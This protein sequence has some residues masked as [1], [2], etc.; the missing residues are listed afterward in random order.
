M[1][2]RNL[3]GE[4]LGQLYEHWYR[5]EGVQPFGCVAVVDGETFTSAEL[6]EAVNRLVEE[7]SIEERQAF[8]GELLVNGVHRAEMEGYAQADLA[9]ISKDQRDL[10]MIELAKAY[11]EDPN[12]AGR[13]YSQFRDHG[14]EDHR[15]M[16]HFLLLSVAGFVKTTA[17]G[18]YE[19]T[20]AG[21]DMIRDCRRV[22]AL[23]DRFVEIE[24]LAP[25]PRG[26][27][28]ETLIADFI[29][30]DGS[31]WHALWNVTTS[32]EQ[33]D[34]TIYRDREYYLM[35][36]KWEKGPAGAPYV[37]ELYGK[38]ENRAGYCGILA[39]MGGFT[40]GA[41]TQVEEYKNRRVILLFGNDSIRAIIATSKTFE[42][43]LTEK[44]HALVTKGV[45][46]TD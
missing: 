5:D 34:V 41:V 33:M 37:R 35:E 18:R 21:L 43:I 9:N 45:V 30:N 11:E 40:E 3:Q 42:E 46:L 36:T 7:G 28:L 12:R 14:I 16:D 25:Q 31:G 10:L 32:H 23:Q 24:A 8:T 27:A 39:S 38:I 15:V 2:K 17:N 29:E 44:Y 22:W 6:R 1:T 19:I 26:T 20:T 4:I 13:H